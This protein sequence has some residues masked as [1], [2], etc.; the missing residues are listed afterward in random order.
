M[1]TRRVAL[2]TALGTAASSAWAQSVTLKVTAA[3]PSNPFGQVSK[4][5]AAAFSRQRPDIAV[6][7]SATEREL[8]AIV[9]RTLRE[10]TVGALPDVSFHAS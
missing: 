6:E 10:A 9:Q 2:A 7:G 1:L 4:D 5:V 3:P 8:E